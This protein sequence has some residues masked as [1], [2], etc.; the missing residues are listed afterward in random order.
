MVIEMFKSIWS[1]LFKNSRPRRDYSGGGKGDSAANEFTHPPYQ[2]NE[3]D[4]G[5]RLP[6]FGLLVLNGFIVGR[7]K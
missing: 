1:L 3:I 4:I 5:R 2:D 6:Y 7:K